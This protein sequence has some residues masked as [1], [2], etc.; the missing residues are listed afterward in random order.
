MTTSKTGKIDLQLYLSIPEVNPEFIS[1]GKNKQML[2]LLSAPRSGS[3]MSR[4]ML[5]GHSKLFSPPELGL[6][7]FNNMKEWSRHF[8]ISE[9]SLDG[10]CFALQELMNISFDQAK[11]LINEMIAKNL[12]T[13]EVYRIMQQHAGDRLIV[14]KTPPNTLSSDILKKAETMFDNAKYILLVRHPYSV[15]ESFVRNRIYSLKGRDKSLDPFLLGEKVWQISNHNMYEFSKTLPEDRYIWVKF[16][17]LVRNTEQVVRQICNFLGYPYEDRLLNPYE[18][19]R[20]LVGPGD[21]N[22]FLHDK[23]DKNMAEQWKEVK[24]PILLNEETCRI[25]DLF[26]Y[27][28]PFEKSKKP[29]KSNM[30]SKVTRAS[31]GN[32]S[33]HDLSNLSNEEVDKLLQEMLKKIRNE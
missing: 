28:L 22:I 21:M 14:D 24:L 4:L 12:P 31:E 9:V 20:M 6:L 8:N 26:K 16:E 3:T 29:V 2:F 11:Q 25:A 27:E 32:L 15:I 10:L 13:Q 23:I 19:N 1:K 17:D 7:I 33:E 18:G 5:G 30:I